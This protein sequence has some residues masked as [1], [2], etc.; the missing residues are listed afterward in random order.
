MP[1]T[2]CLHIQ[3][4]DSDPIRVVELPGSSVRIG[5][6]SYC[7]VRLTEPD[8]ADEECRLRRRGGIWQLVPSRAAGFVWIDGRSVEAAC[9][10]PFDVPFRVGEH[11]LTLRPTGVASPEWQAYKT[12]APSTSTVGREEV[13]PPVATPRGR[14]DSTDLFEFT[15]PPP[16]PTSTPGYDHASRWKDRAEKRAKRS[17]VSPEERRWENRW[18][19]AG[20]RVRARPPVA[21]PPIAPPPAPVANTPPDELAF[22]RA[23][24]DAAELRNRTRRG[25]TPADRRPPIAEVLPS[26]PPVPILTNPLAEISPPSAPPYHAPR[27][28]RVDLPSLEP[29]SELAPATDLPV[30]PSLWTS[31]SPRPS[32][33]QVAPPAPPFAEPIEETFEVVDRLSPS[34]EVD[35]TRTAESAPDG[36]I[37]IAAEHHA[38]F[39]SFEGIDAQP[40]V[41]DDEVQVP[42]SDCIETTVL[43]E[44]DEELV[45]DAEAIAVPSIVAL[46]EPATIIEESALLETP[47]DPIVPAEVG[48]PPPSEIGT[49]PVTVI[50]ESVLLESQLDP[51]ILPDVITPITSVIWTEPAAIVDGDIA[52]E[53]HVEAHGDVEAITPPA[54]AT[55]GEPIEPPGFVFVPEAGLT[56]PDEVI[57]DRPSL[58]SATSIHD[59]A[60]LPRAPG[61]LVSES[62][63]EATQPSVPVSPSG[64]GAVPLESSAQVGGGSTA[65]EAISPPSSR[66]WPTVQDILASHK[67]SVNRA[68]APRPMVRPTLVQ[69]ILTEPRE[70]AHWTFP[71]WLGWP[72]ALI[73]ALIFGVA[74][75]AL[76][77]IWSVD[78]RWSGTVASLLAGGGTSVKALPESVPV[79]QGSWWRSSAVNLMLWSIYFDR[80][81]TDEPLNAA[82]ANRLLTAASQA[83]PIQAQVRFALARQAPPGDRGSALIPSLG[84]SR[85]IEALTWYG[86]Q[87]L[88]LGKKEVAIKVYRRALE[89]AARAD[90]SHVGT[91]A[92]DEDTQILRYHLP[93]ESITGRVIRDMAEQTTWTFAEWK[94]ALPSFAPIPLAAAR[95]LRERGSADADVALDLILTRL[96]APRLE[97]SSA[98]LHLAAQAEAFA[99]KSQWN[100]AKTRYQKALELMP[101]D[102]IKRA[103]W[104][105]LAEIERR[106][107]DDSGRL[108]ALELARG[109]N[110]NDEISQRAVD[111]M[112]FSGTRTDKVRP[113][114]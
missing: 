10:L 34:P 74:G 9:P 5:R 22:R 83:S 71:L 16:L 62:T 2:A 37:E 94:D 13:R 57:P 104:M 95:L 53:L 87:W 76:S 35:P 38:E 82:E 49:E 4:R 17:D 64:D 8:L 33:F 43:T 77:C 6:A 66:D 27:L 46:T 48:P 108:I 78:A 103:W 45:S 59:V 79:P 89:M 41:T 88:L 36:L 42:A 20:E 21:P 101:I 24:L 11:W 75:V 23:S 72:P 65:K 70:P 105:N 30:D 112:R 12:P 1:E 55:L 28:P 26:V 18:R 61:T 69:P 54:A 51:V 107:N 7:E 113:Q 93:G 85:D 60:E 29:R 86:H 63:I 102:A 3:A 109:N 98:S 58:D 99:F 14:D 73:A 68:A 44:T 47:A 25:I 39:Q 92:F 91:P 90:L 84:M 110:T 40:L 111:L 32:A 31:E 52:T 19:A 106:L 80:R 81:A 56:V 67:A 100:E 15:A 97:G 50:D 96:D 114:R